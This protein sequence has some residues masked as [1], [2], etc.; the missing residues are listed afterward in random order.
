MYYMFKKSYFL[1]YL[2]NKIKCNIYVNVIKYL[3][4]INCFFITIVNCLIKDHF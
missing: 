1:K 3:Q 4:L 2:I